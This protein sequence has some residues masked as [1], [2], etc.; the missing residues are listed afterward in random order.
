MGRKISLTWD[1]ITDIKTEYLTDRI[2]TKQDAHR[3]E[4]GVKRLNMTYA[5]GVTNI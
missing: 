3:T 4:H 1:Y 5:L 2:T